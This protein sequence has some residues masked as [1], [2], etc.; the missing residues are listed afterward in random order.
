MESYNKIVK[1]NTKN[2]PPFSEKE[3]YLKYKEGIEKGVGL[4]ANTKNIIEHEISAYEKK[5]GIKQNLE[6]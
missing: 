6:D 1:D 3:K 4:K 2:P 5:H